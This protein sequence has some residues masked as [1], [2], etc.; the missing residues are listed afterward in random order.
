LPESVIAVLHKIFFPVLD[1]LL[2]LNWYI[3]LP[4]TPQ[5][6][7]EEFRGI[8][9]ASNNL[10]TA[11]EIARVNMIPELTQ[12]ACTI[13]GAWNQSTKGNKLL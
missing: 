9:D 2:D 3:A 8:A 5:R 10:L 6:Y 7:M 13:V 12:A 1:F 11:Q 4:F